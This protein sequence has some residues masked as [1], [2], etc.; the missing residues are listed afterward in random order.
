VREALAVALVALGALGAL[1]YDLASE[2]LA[3][4]DPPD[5]DPVLAEETLYCPPSVPIVTDAGRLA[6]STGSPE[7]IPIR[8]EPARADWTL[9]SQRLLVTRAPHEGVP[10]VGA[11]GGSAV[12]HG[13]FSLDGPRGGAAAAP[14][15]RTASERWYFAAGSSG[16]GFEDTLVITNPFLDESVVRVVFYTPRGP[17]AKAGLAD[18]AVPAGRSIEVAIND[19][20][21]RQPV[22]AAEVSATRGRVVAWKHELRD[23]PAGSGGS[24]S[25][26]APAAAPDWYFPDGALGPGYDERIFVLNPSDREA[27]VTITLASSDRVVQPPDLVELSLPPL[28]SREVPLRRSVP[29]PRRAVAVGA[30]VRS[31]NGVEVVAERTVRYLDRDAPGVAAGTGAARSTQL[32]RLGPAVARAARDAVVILNPGRR[33]STVRIALLGA[34]GAALSPRS[35]Q[36]VR[37]PA[38][39]AVRVPVQRWT[40]EAPMAAQV[41][42]TGAVVV[43]R[44]AYST[45]DSDAAAAMGMALTSPDG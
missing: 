8:V 22:L 14:C 42:A 38:G 24:L 1:A 7:P 31:I 23:D 39:R 4:P 18:V 43:E 16:L 9:D 3:A 30:V 2:P 17:M 6:I 11:F 5:P 19:Y 33:T 36:A 12:A 13:F 29:Q 10:S 28:T 44:S 25:L 26:G 27:I 40:R 37:V 45:R 15:S 35:L 21:L 41:E 32:G 34:S 20:V